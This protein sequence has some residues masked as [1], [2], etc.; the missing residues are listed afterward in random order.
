MFAIDQLRK[1]FK[2]PGNVTV[3]AGGLTIASGGDISTT[4]SGSGHAGQVTITAGSLSIVDGGTI[5]SDTFGQGN[6]GGVSISVTGQLAI[7]GTAGGRFFTGI[8]SDTNPG[9]TGNA[10]D[11]V[12]GAGTLTISNGGISSSALGPS[13][14]LPASTGNAGQVTVSAGS[15]TIA[16]GGDISSTSSGSGHAGQVTV[17]AGSLSIVVCSMVSQAMR[18]ISPTMDRT[19]SGRR[20][21][22]TESWS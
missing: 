15:L 7:T 3:S 1:T 16:G 19:R 21:P 10:G 8:S 9:S 13:N 17:T 4:S 6:A 22:P 14:N 11:V 12:V 20:A 5:L 18:Q 2:A